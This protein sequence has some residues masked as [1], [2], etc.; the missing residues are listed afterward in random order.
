MPYSTNWV[1]APYIIETTYV[2]NITIYDL[3]LALLEY[4]GT[5]QMQP[6]YVLLDFGRTRARPHKMLDTPAAPMV[7]QH[8]NLRW[9]ALVNE[10]GFYSRTTDLLVQDKLKL[11]NNRDDALAFLRGMVRA[12]TGKQL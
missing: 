11:Y 10:Q 9:I 8:D 7:L 5:L 4:F 3:N 6:L 2:G 12:D 1:H